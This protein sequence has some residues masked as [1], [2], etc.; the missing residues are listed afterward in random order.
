MPIEIRGGRESRIT[1]EAMSLVVAA[2]NTTTT[3]SAA[4][5]RSRQ[6]GDKSVS[7][8]LLQFPETV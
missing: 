7:N 1:A 3:I 5:M 4:T 8:K 2:D 6:K